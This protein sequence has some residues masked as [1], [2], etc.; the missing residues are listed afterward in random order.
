MLSSLM[1]Q[2]TSLE[3]DTH[4]SFPEANKEKKYHCFAEMLMWKWCIFAIWEM[5][6]ERPISHMLFICFSYCPPKTQTEPG[7]FCTNLFSVCCLCQHKIISISFYSMVLCQWQTLSST[8]RS[9]YSCAP[10]VHQH[11]HFQALCWN[12][13]WVCCSQ[14]WQYLSR[15]E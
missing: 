14:G 2:H 6:W 9:F 15:L 8:L 10:P 11:C 5:H 4:V 7:L 3:G 1:Y 12:F 13:V